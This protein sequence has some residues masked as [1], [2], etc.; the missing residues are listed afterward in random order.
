MIDAGHGRRRAISL[1]ALLVF[2]ILGFT[3][4]ISVDW[5]SGSEL[6][7]LL[8]AAATLLAIIIGVLSLTRHYS[9]KSNEYLLIG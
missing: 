7:T 2:L 1:G 8:E 9:D 5:Q 6:H 3:I 4:L